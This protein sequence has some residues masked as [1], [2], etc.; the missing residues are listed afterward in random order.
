MNGSSFALAI[1][2]LFFAYLAATGKLFA[3]TDILFGTNLEPK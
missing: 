1:G 2:L 3:I